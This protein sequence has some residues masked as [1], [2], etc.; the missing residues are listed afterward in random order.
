MRESKPMALIL[1][2]FS[3]LSLAIMS[4]AIQVVNM[5]NESILSII[6]FPSFVLIFT[7]CI[8]YN[9]SRHG[10]WIGRIFF[11]AFCVIKFL[12]IIYIMK[13]YWSDA[14]K[15]FA[16]I[17]LVILLT[18]SIIAIHNPVLKNWRERRK[19]GDAAVFE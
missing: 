5:R 6:F 15:V 8:W 3:F 1:F 2:D 10:G 7:I 12:T 16:N 11:Y 4:M 9:C 18:A 19:F 14:T 13:L 17:I